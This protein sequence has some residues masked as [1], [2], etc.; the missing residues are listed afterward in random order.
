MQ[1]YR[2]SPEELFAE[3]YAKAR[4]GGLSHADV[5]NIH[6]LGISLYFPET[7]KVLMNQLAA[8]K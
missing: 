4:G 3:L 6:D 8:L 7:Y 2:N 1:Y 5:V